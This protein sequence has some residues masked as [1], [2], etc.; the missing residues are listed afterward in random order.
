MV[1]PKPMERKT[2]R[3]WWGDSKRPKHIGSACNTCWTG[4]AGS[5]LSLH[6]DW[7]GSL[8][9]INLQK[10]TWDVTLQSTQTISNSNLY[11]ALLY[12]I[13]YAWWYRIYEYITW[14]IKQV[15]TRWYTL[16][17]GKGPTCPQKDKLKL[18]TSI[19]TAG[20]TI[21]IEPFLR[22]FE[23]AHCAYVHMH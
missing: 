19:C 7:L 23:A 21:C 13:K 1:I 16:L 17:P 6:D 2:W 15:V 10:N 18:L 9:H 20:S 14:P 3:L 12:R 22:V 11:P 5:L 8:C 4:Q